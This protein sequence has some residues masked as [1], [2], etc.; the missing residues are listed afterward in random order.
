MSLGG[1]CGNAGTSH[2]CDGSAHSSGYVVNGCGCLLSYY[3]DASHQL[4]QR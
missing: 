1:L 2:L 4:S 3:I